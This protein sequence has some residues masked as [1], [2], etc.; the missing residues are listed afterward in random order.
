MRLSVHLF[1][2]AKD[3]VGDKTLLIEVPANATVLELKEKIQKLFPEFSDLNSLA[4]ARNSEYAIDTDV[5]NNQDEL[6]LI[7]PVS[8]G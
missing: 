4:I 5:I 7:P 1:G 8:G 6:A 3:I 2:I